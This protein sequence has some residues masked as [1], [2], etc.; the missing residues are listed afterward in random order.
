[1]CIRDSLYTRSVTLRAATVT[2]T[3]KACI[4]CNCAASC[5]HQRRCATESSKPRVRKYIIY[6]SLRVGTARRGSE[7]RA[8]IVAVQAFT[9]SSNPSVL[10]VVSTDPHYLQQQGRLTVLV[11]PANASLDEIFNCWRVEFLDG[12][13]RLTKLVPRSTL[14]S[15]IN[16]TVRAPP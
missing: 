16:A 7:V 3:R 1:M 2:G 8:I 11:L 4:A 15:G 5:W 13:V 6:I 14:P 9:T 12:Y 10:P